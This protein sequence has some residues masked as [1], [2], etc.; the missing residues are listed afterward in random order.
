MRC[1]A[2]GHEEKIATVCSR[3]ATPLPAAEEKAAPATPNPPKKP[4]A[5][6]PVPP[7]EEKHRSRPLHDLDLTLPELEIRERE[8][9]KPKVEK[10]RLEEAKSGISTGSTSFKVTDRRPRFDDANAP[11][12][13]GQTATPAPDH[14][15]PPDFTSFI[16]SLGASALLSMGETLLPGAG[17]GPGA[18]P[19]VNLDQAKELID[20]LGLLEEKT[21]GNLTPDESE[22]LTQTLYALRMRYVQVTKIK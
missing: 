10:G 21:K 15:R 18:T 14:P 13:P 8:I 16:Y 22:M 3:C 11:A 19:P 7:K 6:P 9:L 20:L 4:A 1:P 12:D 17:S 2:C 5:V